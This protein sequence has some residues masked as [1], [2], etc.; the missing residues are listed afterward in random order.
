MHHS[1]EALEEDLRAA[2]IAHARIHDVRAVRALD[3]LSGRLTRTRAPGG[4]E[5]RM[6]PMPV[7]LPDAS[8]EF[9]FPPHYG[10]HTHPVLKEAGYGAAECAAL[11]AAG[12]I[13]A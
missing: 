7:D 10:E 13:P 5:I 3:A 12:V 9:A 6:Q 2:T 4:A 8:R 1:A 11:A